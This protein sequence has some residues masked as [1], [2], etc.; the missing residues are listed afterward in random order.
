[1]KLYIDH[2]LQTTTDNQIGADTF[3][4]QLVNNN[5]T[6]LKE[7]ITPYLIESFIVRS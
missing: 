3:V 6:I 7:Q 4:A 1:M 5:K 2:I